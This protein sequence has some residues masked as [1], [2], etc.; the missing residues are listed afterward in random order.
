MINTDDQTVLNAWADMES[1][2]QNFFLNHAKRQR[3]LDEAIS[4]LNATLS[5]TEAMHTKN[6]EAIEEMMASLEE[7]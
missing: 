7:L 2:K 1:L 3:E 5:E 6:A 4:S